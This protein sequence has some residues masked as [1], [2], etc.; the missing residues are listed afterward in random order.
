MLD[1]TLAYHRCTNATA[2]Y[3]SA[4]KEPTSYCRAVIQGG[5]LCYAGEP[6]TIGTT[7]TAGVYAIVRVRLW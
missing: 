5:I 6:F 3:E 1:V 7:L 4:T 2:K